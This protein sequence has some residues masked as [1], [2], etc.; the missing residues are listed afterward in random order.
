[1]WIWVICGWTITKHMHRGSQIASKTVTTSQPKL[2]RRRAIFPVL[3]RSV[4]PNWLKQISPQRTWQAMSKERTETTSIIKCF[5]RRQLRILIQMKRR[6]CNIK[7]RLPKT[8][9]S[10][11]TPLDRIKWLIIE[12]LKSLTIRRK[13]HLHKHYNPRW[14]L[15]QMLNQQQVRPNQKPNSLLQTIRWR[16]YPGLKRA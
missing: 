14:P 11:L 10:R 1:M 8:S 13:N 3:P 9:S 6:I 2:G 4:T 16:I 12:R 15:V 5:S 7:H